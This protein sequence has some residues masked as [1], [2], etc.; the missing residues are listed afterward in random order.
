MRSEVVAHP[1]I[2]PARLVRSA[3]P[4][5]QLTCAVCAPARVVSAAASQAVWRA[6]GRAVYSHTRMS[7]RIQSRGSLHEY[8]L[9]CYFSIDLLESVSRDN[10][11]TLYYVTL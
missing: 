10:Y 11:V 9:E 6:L 7:H 4:P 3:T 2:I 8:V 5:L 1:C